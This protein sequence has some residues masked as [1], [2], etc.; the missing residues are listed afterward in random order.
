VLDPTAMRA[1]RSLV[2][3]LKNYE[4]G[5]PCRAAGLNSETLSLT[6]SAAN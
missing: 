2:Q 5:I 4:A 1:L 3:I 6:L